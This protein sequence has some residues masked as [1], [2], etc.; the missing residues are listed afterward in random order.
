VQQ[1]QGKDVTF[2]PVSLKWRVFNIEIPLADDPGKDDI[3][4]HTALLEKLSKKLGLKDKDKDMLLN[5]LS[6]ENEDGSGGIEV[7]VARK[8]F[9]ARWKKLG[10]PKFVYTVDISL[11]KAKAQQF[12]L[13]P[14]EGKI[15]P[16]FDDT[17]ESIPGMP[18]SSPSGKRLKRAVVVGAGP[19]GLFAALQLANAGLSPIIIERGQPVERRGR[20]IGALFNRKVLNG[21]SNLCYGEGGAGTWS[22]GKL[23]TRIGK[24]S[25]EVR[26]VLE[27]LVA[28]GAPERILVDGKPHLGTDRLVRIL[29][30]LRQHL[31]DLG[32]TFRFGTRVEDIVVR[33]NGAVGGVIVA[34]DSAAAETIEAE[35]VV[36]AVGHSARLLY[37]RLLGHGVH[38]ECKPIAVGFRVEHPQS[39]I[40]KIQL[41]QFGDLCG[42]GA[43][44]VPVA[45]YRLAVEVE[46]GDDDDEAQK[47]RSVYSFC[48]CPGGQIVPTSVRP[49]ELCLNGM[50][51]SKRQ[52]QWANSALVVGVTPD[53]MEALYP[54]AWPMRGVLFQEAMERRAAQFGGGNLVAPVQRVTD[55]IEGKAILEGSQPS[56]SYRMGVKAAACHEIYPPFITEALRKALRHFDKE[57][58][59]FVSEEALLHGVE[60]RTSAP[61]Q[62]TRS[63]DSLECVSLRGLFPAGEGAGYAGGIVSAAVDGMA[64]GTKVVAAIA[65]D[66]FVDIAVVVGGATNPTVKDGKILNPLTNRWVSVTGPVGRKLLL[67]GMSYR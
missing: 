31:Q 26:T 48:M 21:E 14:Q 22:D 33:S 3:G 37:E 50:S 6:P 40:N 67:D 55:F 53:D 63:A 7:K 5:I 58:P 52:S 62:I 1:T 13:R 27:T 23:T 25:R 39:L 32:C 60:T 8:A 57:M 59:G 64:V 49:D 12:R 66:P 38:L 41:G 45:D 44:P 19:A 56:S 61:V 36:L 11:P 18:S 43:G 17:E 51:F 46:V 65:K 9:D 47:K 2:Q 16:I 34:S 24:N 4:L 28:Q 15:E 54:G 42:R 20:D 29:R 35:V 10:Q 30:Q